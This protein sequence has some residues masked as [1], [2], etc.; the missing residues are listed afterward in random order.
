MSEIFYDCPAKAMIT[1][2]KGKFSLDILT[3]IFNG[4]THY[5]QLLRTIPEINSRILAKRLRDFEEIGILKR[6]I[7]VA[8]PPMSI[9]YDLTE[10]GRALNEV[11]QS[12][13]NWMKTYE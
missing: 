10:K 6:T 12:M 2:F 1:L 8:E 3:Q 5:N 4:T 9:R 7:L 13:A 11:V